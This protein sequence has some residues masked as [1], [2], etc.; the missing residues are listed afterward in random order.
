MNPLTDSANDITTTKIGDD[1]GGC[2]E[3]KTK[4]FEP[5]NGPLTNKS[6]GTYDELALKSI[7]PSGPLRP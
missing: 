7:H 2:R 5:I 1:L 6:R 3:T 4:D